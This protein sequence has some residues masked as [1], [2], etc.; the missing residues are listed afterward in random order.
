VLGG[1]DAT[2]SQADN[3]PMCG[4]VCDCNTRLDIANAEIYFEFFK[5]GELNYLTKDSVSAITDTTGAFCHG[6]SDSLLEH[7]IYYTAVRDGYVTLRSEF[8]L[9]N[10]TRIDTCLTKIGEQKKVESYGIFIDGIVRN[11]QGD[12]LTEATI[13]AKIDDKIQ[14][15]PLKMTDSTGEFS[16]VFESRFLGRRLNWKISKDRYSDSKGDFLIEGDKSLYVTLAP[17][18]PPPKEKTRRSLKRD[19]LAGVSLVG[20]YMG[21]LVLTGSI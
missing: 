1:L 8:I 10:N 17:L 20:M 19:I 7:R 5:P 3:V 12:P 15:S 21:M 9:G 2:L 14:L 18:L 11:D 6:F 13:D 4:S 16:W